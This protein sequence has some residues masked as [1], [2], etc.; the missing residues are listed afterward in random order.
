MPN[1]KDKSTC[2][3]IAREFCSN[4]RNKEQA[5]ISVGYTKSY[6]RSG[7][8]HTQIYANPGVKAAIAKIDAKMAKEI[9]HNRIISLH[10]LQKAYDLAFKQGNAAA[11]VAAER[12]KNAISNLHSSTLHTDD[13]QTKE[14]NDSQQAEARRL[15]NIRL[16]QA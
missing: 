8:A 7:Y 15:A 1:I 16:K 13:K 10:N 3:A 5:L 2:D 6:A 14:L 12:E 11:M 4:G 9:E